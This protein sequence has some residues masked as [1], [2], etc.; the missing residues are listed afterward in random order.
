MG[1]IIGAVVILL[2]VGLVIKFW[3]IILPIIAAVIAAFCI[4]K[5][6]HKKKNAI[7]R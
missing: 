2:M 5:Y 7:S 6:Q 4:Y 3:F 1:Y